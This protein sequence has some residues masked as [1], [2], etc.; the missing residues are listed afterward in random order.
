[1]PGQHSRAIRQSEEGGGG[2][3]RSQA[4]KRKKL[5]EKTLASDGK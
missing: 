5:K 2:L 1:V 4:K 3:G